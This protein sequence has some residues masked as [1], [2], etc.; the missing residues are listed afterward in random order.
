MFSSA[1]NDQAVMAQS[2][3][4]T[5]DEAGFCPQSKRDALSIAHS[6]RSESHHDMVDRSSA[7]VSPS[8]ELDSKSRNSTRRRIQVAV[9]YLSKAEMRLQKG[10]TLII[11][12]VTD[13]GKERSNVVATVAMD[14]VALTASMPETRIVNS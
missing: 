2:Y 10:Q 12:S 4:S 8:S 11:T 6:V 9:S 1:L 13:V 7:C 14:M 5:V 3:Y